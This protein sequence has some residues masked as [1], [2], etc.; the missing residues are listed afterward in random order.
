MD[1][2]SLEYAFE[3]TIVY[4]KKPNLQ[5]NQSRIIGK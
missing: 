3:K 4:Q 1:V 5:I 2:T